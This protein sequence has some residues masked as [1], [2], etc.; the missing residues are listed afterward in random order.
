MAIEANLRV[1]AWVVRKKAVDAKRR[2]ANKIVKA[3]IV[4]NPSKPFLTPIT[5]TNG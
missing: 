4:E 3:F 2:T 5:E 1:K